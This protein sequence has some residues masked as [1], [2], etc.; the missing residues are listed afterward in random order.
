MIKSHLKCP[1]CQAMF[2]FENTPKILKNCQH[3]ICIN[4]LKTLKS[5]YFSKLIQVV[6]LIRYK[7]IQIN[8]ELKVF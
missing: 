4:C 7:S 2:G 3:T 8:G 5:M 6:L 1:S